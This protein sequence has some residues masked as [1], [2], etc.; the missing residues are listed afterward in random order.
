MEELLADGEYVCALADGLTDSD[1]AVRIAAVR[2]IAAFAGA[3]TSG[4]Q[5]PKPQSSVIR[6]ALELA[7]DV[8]IRDRQPSV[9]REAMTALATVAVGRKPAL[10]CDCVRSLLRELGG[11][12][13]LPAL[14]VLSSRPLKDLRA[15]VTAVVAIET[16]LRRMQMEFV[17]DV[18]AESVLRRLD[19]ALTDI[20]NNNYALACVGDLSRESSAKLV[21]HRAA[22]LSH[23]TCT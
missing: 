7:S 20:V 1:A 9:R 6:I 3:V 22:K 21:P 4:Q 18:H 11:D 13:C 23:R 19:S 16:E 8:I 14:D 10:D 17:G 5:R 2:A 12:N 15:F